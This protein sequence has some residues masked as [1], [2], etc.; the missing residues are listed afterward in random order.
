MKGALDK[1][2]GYNYAPHRVNKS[3]TEGG[4]A[5]PIGEFGAR[6]VSKAIPAV[7]CGIKIGMSI[8]ESSTFLPGN[9]F[10]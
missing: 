6:T 4:K 8:S 10:V 1:S 7:W 9:S 3:Y 2:H 5:A